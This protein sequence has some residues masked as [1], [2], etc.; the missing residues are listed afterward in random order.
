MS[1]RIISDDGTNPRAPRVMSHYENYHS[2][3]ALWIL[4]AMVLRILL[5]IDEFPAI[6]EQLYGAWR[7]DYYLVWASQRMCEPCYINADDSAY[8]LFRYS[9]RGACINNLAILTSTRLI[10]VSIPI[11]NFDNMM[12][13]VRLAVALIVMM[14]RILFKG[15][16]EFSTR[17]TSGNSKRS[18][19][20]PIGLLH[21]WSR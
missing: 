4:V 8:R 20:W 10:G 11:A 21:H 1:S 14:Y 16:F 2:F 18:V 9:N 5:G 3:L 19:S 17:K 6:V 7:Y 13:L 15:H 12:V